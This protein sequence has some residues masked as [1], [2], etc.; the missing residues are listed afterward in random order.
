MKKYF[1]IILTVTILS[2]FQIWARAIEVEPLGVEI[3]GF[4]S[5]GFL[6]STSYNYLASD[7][8]R[9]SFQF[10]EIGLNFNKKVTP[11][12]RI[13]AQFFARDL[14]DAANNKVTLDWALGDYRFRDW[15]NVRAGRIKLPRGI[16]NEI[17]D[18]DMLRGPI[19]L[20]QGI[21][22]ELNR[23]TLI[24]VNGAGL[25]GYAP[26]S[27]AG[28]LEYQA[29]AGTTN[30]DPDSGTG[31]NMNAGLRG[32]ATAGSVQARNIYAGSLKW[33]T[34]LDGLSLKCT[35]N[36]MEMS[37][38][39]T[40]LAGPLAGQT[41]QMTAKTSEAIFSLEY[42]WK[43][44]ALNAEYYMRR[45]EAEFLLRAPSTTK[46]ESYY[47][48]ASYRLLQPLEIGG[49][50]S[51]YYPNIENRD[52]AKRL[53]TPETHNAWMK[54]AAAFIRFDVSSFTTVKLEAHYVE[55]TAQVLYQDNPARVDNYWWY[56]A[57]KATFSF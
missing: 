41:D 29:L 37:A 20:P 49:Y 32:E 26:L 36:W 12:L 5:Q 8:N 52:G 54:D 19:I 27:A 40:Y 1:I 11:N 53:I 38:P 3:H 43:D 2:G 55:G 46:A 18:Q 51:V 47:V 56:F 15:L 33:N 48:L 22:E 57:A 50:Y 4:V 9:G 42:I 10:N 6:K 23:D 39:I 21:Y 14:G 31:K 17:R 28:S 13:G 16:Y 44:L 30:I 45:Q 34:F 24:A 7:S 25:Y 35:G